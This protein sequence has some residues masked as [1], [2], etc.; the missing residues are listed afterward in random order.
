MN[1]TKFGIPAFAAI[2][3]I[4]FSI[5]E[6]VARHEAEA[7]VA[8]LQKENDA[9]HR[10]VTKLESQLQGWSATAHSRPADSSCKSPDHDAAL[11]QL[12][13]TVQPFSVYMSDSR[14]CGRIHVTVGCI[15]CSVLGR[16]KSRSL[17]KSKRTLPNP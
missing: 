11:D 4:G 6:T 2:F 16:T 12:I 9:E 13:A 15:A 7:M 5:R 10:L 8:G 14:Q 3:A 1:L 17:K